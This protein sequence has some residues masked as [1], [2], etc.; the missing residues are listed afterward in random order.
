MSFMSLN[1]TTVSFA[2]PDD[3]LAKDSRVFETNEGLTED[4]VEK[5]LIRSTDR[6]LSRIR[7][8][9]WWR[10]YYLKRQSSFNIQSYADIP[11]PDL[12]KVIKRQD[13]FTDLCVY[14]AL[15][16]YI[17]PRV[18]DFGDENDSDRAKM[19]YYTTKAESLFS[20]I[21]NS[22]DWYDFDDNSVI[23]KDE[24]HPGNYRLKR[25]R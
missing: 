6:I 24:A 4:D 1:N 8:T 25:V 13:D 17:L 15:A 11:Y 2:E 19:G 22:G 16:D 14:T 18:A 5:A 23:D 3:V 21:I 10:N 9:D 7:S 20:E 12:D